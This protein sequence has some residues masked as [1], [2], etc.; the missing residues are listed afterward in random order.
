[1]TETW[2]T[3][4]RCLCFAFQPIALSSN[5]CAYGYEALLRGWKEAGFFSIGSV[6]DCAYMENALVDLDQRL[7]AKAFADFASWAPA[8]T[9]L[10]YNVDNRI[11]QSPNPGKD[12]LAGI[13]NSFGLSAH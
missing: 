2:E 7:R 9:K 6:F 12:D 5:G 3:A 11:F 13:E 8:G 1:M 10:F 4:S